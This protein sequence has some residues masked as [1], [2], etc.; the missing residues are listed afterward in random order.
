MKSASSRSVERTTRFKTSSPT[1]DI[2]E[3]VSAEANSAGRNFSSSVNMP[4]ANKRVTRALDSVRLSPASAVGSQASG[5]PCKVRN[6]YSST[7]RP[8]HRIEAATSGLA[9]RATVKSRSFPN[10]CERNFASSACTPKEER[11]SSSSLLPRRGS[12]KC[13]RSRRIRWKSWEACC[14]DVL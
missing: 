10:Q 4:L 7:A 13:V 11:S 8:G 9:V 2:R 1:S 5:L 6:L 12:L 14:W 3:F